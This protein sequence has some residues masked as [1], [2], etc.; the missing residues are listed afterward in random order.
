MRYQPPLSAA[1]DHLSSPSSAIPAAAKRCADTRTLLP[2]RRA[3]RLLPPT[4]S[5]LELVARITR[6]RPGRT[7]TLLDEIG[8]LH[9]LVQATEPELR[10]HGVGI[11]AARDLLDAI[12]LGRRTVGAA[13]RRGRKLAA[14][15]DVFEHLRA[16]LASN[17][18]EE[19][20]VVAMDVRQRGLFENCLAR[21]SLTGVEVHPRDVFRPLIRAAAA[22]A[23]FCHNHPSGDPEPSLQ[24]IRLTARL[25]E[26]GELCG[27]TVLDHVVVAA[28]GFVSLA[29][30]GWKRIAST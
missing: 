13:P 14:A 21:G 20:W 11:Q 1:L 25:R 8:G 16:R 2:P 27:I 17:P 23:I 5:D 12:D 9:G 10:A 24:D 4:P 28:D 18:V 22:I 26:T 19:F 7:A 29:D 15:S 30:R 3:P 6:L